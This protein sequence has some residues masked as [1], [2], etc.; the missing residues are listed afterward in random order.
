M[1]N[2]TAIQSAQQ[3]APGAKFKIAVELD[4]FPV[5]IEFEGKSDNLKSLVERLKTIGAQPPQAKPAAKPGVP[6]CPIHNTP[7]KAS[8]KPGTFFCPKR[9]DD[10]SYC[11][12]KA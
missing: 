1:S 9:T 2:M 4:G 7:M 3:A 8:Q 10:G 11:K 5:E 12:E 6:I